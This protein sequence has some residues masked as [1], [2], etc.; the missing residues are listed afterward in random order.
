M[1]ALTREEE[2][3]KDW[4]NEPEGALPR[5]EKWVGVRDLP[6]SARVLYHMPEPL[7]CR[8]HDCLAVD[9]KNLRIY[10]WQLQDVLE[11]TVEYNRFL[12][13]EIDRASRFLME[14]KELAWF[15][16]PCTRRAID[17]DGGESVEMID[18]VSSSSEGG[19]EGDGM[20]KDD[21]DISSSG[22]DSDGEDPDGDGDDDV[23]NMA[24]GGE[25][26]GSG[27]TEKDDE[28]GNGDPEWT[29]P[30]QEGDRRRLHDF[31]EYS[32]SVEKVMSESARN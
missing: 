23:D 4:R 16:V 18:L 9:R 27:R 19:D 8:C 12:E 32:G 21:D 5:L 25:V 29:C 13:E 17:A 15:P 22:G 10:L 6:E 28:P 20:G 11:E 14:A 3:E 7:A 2:E 31:S 30:G 26:G 24:G 1:R